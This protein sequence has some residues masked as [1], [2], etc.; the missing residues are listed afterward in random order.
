MANRFLSVTKIEKTGDAEY[1]A[2]QLK[3][4]VSLSTVIAL[5]S[6]MDAN[7]TYRA[8]EELDRLY[9]NVDRRNARERAKGIVSSPGGI[10]SP[11]GDDDEVGSG[12][13]HGAGPG[14][15]KRGGRKKVNPEG[16]G[17]RC[18]NCG[19]IGHIKT[20]KK[21]CPL[22]NGQKKQSD[23]F[24]DASAASPAAV[25]PTTSFAGSPS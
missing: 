22:L 5:P 6:A 17:R 16:T 4:F 10:N 8:E 11:M 13:P 3:A 25:A 18:A 14:T 24:R 19:Q 21:L 20:N 2:M 23:T 9:R 7:N 1:D 12:T 15:G